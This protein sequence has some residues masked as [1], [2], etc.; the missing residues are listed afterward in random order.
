MASL[1][2]FWRTVRHLRRQQL[3]GRVHF[4]LSRPRPDVR[5]GPLA[6]LGVGKI[7]LPARRAASLLGPTLFNLLSVQH[8]LNQVGW[9]NPSLDLLWRYHQH[10]FDDL[11]ADAAESRT[12]WHSALVQ[13]WIDE[14]PPARGTG[15]SPY[16]LS[17]R[18]VN[19]IK[20]FRRDQSPDPKWLQSL[21]TQARWLSKRL[22]W[23][24]LGNHLFMNAKALVY[25]GLFFAGDEAD[26]WLKLGTQILLRELPEQILADG[27]QFERSPMYH[28]LALEDLLDLLNLL[29]GVAAPI[30]V[31][32]ELQSALRLRS[33][34]MLFWLRCMSHPDGSLSLFNDT[35]QGIAPVNGEIERLAAELGVH[36]GS[37]AAEGLTYLAHSGY[38]RLARGSAVALIDLAPV[39]PDYLPGHAHADTLSF[40]MSLR[41]RQVIVNRGTSVYGTGAR[42]LLERGTAAHSTVQIGHHDS[43]EVWS[44][45]RVGRRAYPVDLKVSD[46][47]ISGSHDGYR[48]LPGR[49]RHR[50]LWRLQ[51]NELSV[52]DWVEGGAGDAVAR[53][54][55][56]PGLRA[57]PDGRGGWQVL[58]GATAV[59]AVEVQGG[60]T[61]VEY[62]QHARGF[63]QLVP[64]QTLTVALAHGHASTRWTWG[65]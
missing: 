30:G 31:L 47:G 63:G 4:K 6:R 10:Y 2:T 46:D 33:Q 20:W 43:S 52:D 36:A 38:L 14:N 59:A 23:H 58:D 32:R 50:R 9:D 15:W 19:W 24:L 61:V 11:N 39:G 13:R 49:P 5:P 3:L 54:H 37:P 62:W 16:P 17:I 18:I 34:A 64:A 60:S 53:Y 45:F 27:G 12:A 1:G 26:Q 56:D 55:L 48:F 57:L 40:E 25:A 35:A 28:A 42:R 7:A 44:G 22:E 51:G 8:D 21:A 29:S 65:D 41:G